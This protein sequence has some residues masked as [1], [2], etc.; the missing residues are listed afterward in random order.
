MRTTGS[1]S[2]QGSSSGAPRAR[3][4]H[5]LRIGQTRV[6]KMGSTRLMSGQSCTSTRAR[7]CPRRSRR[8]TRRY[9]TRFGWSCVSQSPITSQKSLGRHWARERTWT[10]TRERASRP[11]SA[12]L[13]G[14]GCVPT[15]CV[16]SIRTTSPSGP[17]SEIGG[18]GSTCSCPSSPT[19]A[20]R[21]C[22]GLPRSFSSTARMSTSCACT[23]RASSR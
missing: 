10:E 19:M 22:T 6:S 17:C 13:A 2:Q 7:R 18:G 20:S 15:G 16:P 9:S 1:R 8:S 23:S 5:T 14:F 3:S 21:L 4:R 12:P 11:R